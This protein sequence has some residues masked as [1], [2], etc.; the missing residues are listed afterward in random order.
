MPLS[1]SLPLAGHVSVLPHSRCRDMGGFA[2]W[3]RKVKVPKPVPKPRGLSRD[4]QGL[5]LD[6]PSQPR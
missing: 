3:C 1:P 5:S 6:T 4:L 2:I